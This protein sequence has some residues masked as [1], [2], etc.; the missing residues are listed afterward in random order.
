MCALVLIPLTLILGS[1]A[2]TA[3]AQKAPAVEK[4]QLDNGLR[5]FGRPQ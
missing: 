5:V 4:L 3:P 2:T 1:T